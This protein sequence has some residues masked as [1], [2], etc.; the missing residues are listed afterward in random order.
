MHLSPHLTPQPKP[1]FLGLG[2]GLQEPAHSK[3]IF[4]TCVP[5]NNHPKLF[6]SC[7]GLSL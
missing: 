2:I 6:T 7:K 4:L 1:R 5:F 3:R